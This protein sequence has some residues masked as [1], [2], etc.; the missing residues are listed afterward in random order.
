MGKENQHSKHENVMMKPIR[1][2]NGYVLIIS[3]NLQRKMEIQKEGQRWG[4]AGEWQWR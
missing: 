1:M 3:F 2:Q 4:G